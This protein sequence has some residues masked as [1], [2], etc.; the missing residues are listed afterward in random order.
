MFYPHSKVSWM[1]ART[2]TKVTLSRI[3]SFTLYYYA[4]ALI[5][6]FL[7]IFLCI[8]LG[9]FYEEYILNFFR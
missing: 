1:H 2:A 4:T 6:S 3:L 8:L 5:F 9:H 7:F